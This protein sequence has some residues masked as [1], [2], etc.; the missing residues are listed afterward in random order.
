MS[1]RVISFEDE[2]RWQEMYKL[3]TECV[4]RS[5]LPEKFRV[6]LERIG[7]KYNE[8]VS[9]N[10]ANLVS[11]TL[12]IGWTLVDKRGQLKLKNEKGHT[13]FEGYV[14]DE[15]DQ[16]KWWYEEEQFEAK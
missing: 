4:E 15:D 2:P 3:A 7:V 9:T 13:K 12:P 14:Y 5:V 1:R 6:C 16:F 8:A 11:V 10:E